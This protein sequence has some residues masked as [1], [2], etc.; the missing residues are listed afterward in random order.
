MSMQANLTRL[1]RPRQ[2]AFVGSIQSEGS[3][4][5]CR[6]AGYAGEMW[7]VSPN[8]DEIG[9]IPCVREISDLPEA[10]DVALLALSPERTV[11]AIKALGEMG[12]GGAVCMS[13]GYAEMNE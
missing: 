11:A 2:I 7:T 13:A 6:R 8:R 4:A 9:G 12:A 1:L 3:I 5:A 10:P